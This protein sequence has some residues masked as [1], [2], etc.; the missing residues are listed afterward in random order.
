MC[1]N[2]DFFP[3]LGRHN[4]FCLLYRVYPYLCLAVK[5]FAQNKEVE[6]KKEF[7]ISFIDVPSTLKL[8]PIK[9]KIISE[10]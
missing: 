9:F 7:Y 5:H 4:R 6:A 2:V 10:I 3:L 8:V 1:K